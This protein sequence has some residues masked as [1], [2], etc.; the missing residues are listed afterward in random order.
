MRKVAVF[1]GQCLQDIAIRE[2]GGLEGIFLIAGVNGIS[3]TQAVE[4]TELE[5]PK[6]YINERI[7]LY[8]LKNKIENATAETVITVFKLGAITLE[9]K[10]IEEK[11]Q[12]GEVIAMVNQNLQD[13]SIET[14]GTLE[15]IFELALLNGLKITEKPV[16]GKRYNAEFAEKENDIV[17]YYIAKGIKP[18]TGLSAT[19]GCYYAECEYVEKEY[20]T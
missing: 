5:I 15:S 10:N 14:T 20:W 8:Y 11:E 3:I 19:S 16:A 7:S 17:N 9:S 2:M 6:K 4:N 13:L 12:K 1:N 18:A